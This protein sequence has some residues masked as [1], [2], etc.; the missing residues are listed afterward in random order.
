MKVSGKKIL[1]GVYGAVEKTN[2]IVACSAPELNW[3]VKNNLSRA[4]EWREES[5]SFRFSGPENVDSKTY[6]TEKTRLENEIDK[7]ILYLEKRSLINVIRTDFLYRISV[8]EKGIETARLLESVR[9]QMVLW[10]REKRIA[11]ILFAV[12]F[13]ICLMS[14]VAVKIL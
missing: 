14:A 9:G 2:G 6:L 13:M 7:N 5:G 3:L 4:G 8:T 12:L 10:F 1:F 11:F